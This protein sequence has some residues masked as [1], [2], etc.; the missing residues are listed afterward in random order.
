MSNSTV[1][2]K[3]TLKAPFPR[4]LAQYRKNCVFILGGGWVGNKPQVAILKV[5]RISTRY[6]VL[7]LGRDVGG[8]VFGEMPRR[9]S[10]TRELDSTS[11]PD[12][13]LTCSQSLPFW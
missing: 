13:A 6:I 11:F 12:I 2:A 7:Y 4:Q 5:A 3:S 1:E 10:V 8:R 9:N